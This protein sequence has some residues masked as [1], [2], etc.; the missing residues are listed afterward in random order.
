MGIMKTINT[1][2]KRQEI[3]QVAVGNSNRASRNA[4]FH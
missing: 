1:H 4:I 2:M 3:N